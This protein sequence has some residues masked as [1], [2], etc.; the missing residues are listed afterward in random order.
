MISLISKIWT[1]P[2]KHL[3]FIFL[4]CYAIPSHAIVFNNISLTDRELLDQ[5]ERSYATGA[6]KGFGGFKQYTLV[7]LNIAYNEFKDPYI[8]KYLITDFMGLSE[9]EKEK[10]Y[11]IEPISDMRFNTY[12]YGGNVENKDRYCI[13]NQ[14]GIL[15]I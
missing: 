13:E 2:M 3:P 6:N 9:K 4:L 1:H 7:D 11:I 14:E 8:L 10:K 12:Y 5:I 15:Q